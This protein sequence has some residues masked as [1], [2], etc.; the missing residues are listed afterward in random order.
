[1]LGAGMDEGFA[2]A[3]IFRFVITSPLQVDGRA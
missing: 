2:L 3:I 1:M